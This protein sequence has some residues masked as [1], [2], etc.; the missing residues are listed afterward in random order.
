V[1]EK[2]RNALGLGTGWAAQQPT[3]T[4]ALRHLQRQMEHV[5]ILVVV[6]GIVRN[7]THRKL[8]VEEFRG[9]VLVDEFAPLVFVNGAD[10]K[11]AQMFTLA[12][13]LAHIWFGK[14]AAFD[15]RQLQ[16]ASDATEQACNRV[17]AEL[18]VPE[19]VLRSLWTQL[20]DG[21]QRYQQLARQFKI[22]E[23]VVARRVLDLDLID[24]E[25]FLTFYRNYLQKEREQGTRHRGGN[26]YATQ[27]LRIG[28]R[29][30]EAVVRAVGEGE[31]LYREAYQLTGLYGEAFERYASSL[32]STEAA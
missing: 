23:L 16:A 17:A 5:G 32:S 30:A 26:F 7:N 10:A 29:F 28:R 20:S 9:F 3:W 27:N 31:L 1:A 24:R 6:N 14:S 18:L 25:E 22:S 12:H 4:D 19:Q 13:E 2:M 21:P 8:D 11:A 15:L